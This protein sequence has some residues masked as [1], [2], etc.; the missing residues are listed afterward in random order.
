MGVNVIIELNTLGDYFRE[1]GKCGC[2]VEHS[3]IFLE[4]G[5]KLSNIIF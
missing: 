5:A 2:L 4:M 3:R 1:E